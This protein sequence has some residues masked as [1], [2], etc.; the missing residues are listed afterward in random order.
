MIVPFGPVL[1]AAS[2]KPPWTSPLLEIVFLVS[3]IWIWLWGCVLVGQWFP[4]RGA[5]TA[6]TLW[7]LVVEWLKSL[8]LDVWFLFPMWIALSRL[9][10]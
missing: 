5:G 8:F 4:D 6:L 1:L 10:W 2:L 7:Q 9:S 3:P